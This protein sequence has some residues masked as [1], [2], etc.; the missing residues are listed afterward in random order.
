LYY[1]TTWRN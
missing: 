1:P